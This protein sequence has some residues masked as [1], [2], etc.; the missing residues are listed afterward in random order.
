MLKIRI[1]EIWRHRNETTF[2]PYLNNAMMFRDIGV[3]FV[4]E[5]NDYDLTWVG[6]ASIADKNRPLDVAMRMGKQWLQDNVHGDYILFDGQDSASMIGSY[7]I[8]QASNAKLFLKNTLYT[9]RSDYQRKSIHGRTYWGS[10]EDYTGERY[11]NQTEYGTVN[12]GRLNLPEDYDFSIY[13]PDFTNIKL[14]GANWLSTITPQWFDIKKKDI[15]VFAMFQYPAKYNEE[16]SRRSHQ[17]YDTHRKRCVDW[18][19]MLPPS[20]KVAK[21]IDGAKVPIEEYYALMRR[22]KI[23]VAPFGYGEIAPRDIES[24]MLNAVLV[25]PDMG[26]IETTPNPYIPNVTYKACKWDYSDMN[27]VIVDVL[28]NYKEYRDEY[29]SNLRNIYADQYSSEKIVT[30]MHN[31]IANLDGFGTV[32]KRSVK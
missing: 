30:Y 19:N 9:D 29:V 21:L 4:F 26:H 23:I 28:D 12:A 18:I 7:E 14:S 25:K 15:D 1:A 10:S 31:I 17:F 11:Y 5:G 13:N 22:S 16:F 2:R 24:A 8:F 27:D 6:Q 3:E 32:R 20:I